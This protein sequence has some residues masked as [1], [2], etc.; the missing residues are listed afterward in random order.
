MLGKI[1]HKLG[2]AG[3]VIAIMALVAALTGVA[4]AAG[5][6][7]K[8][9]EKQVKKIVNKEIQ[10]H[11][12]PQGPKGDPGAPGSQ[13]P[14]GDPGAPG[15]NGQNGISPSGTEFSGEEGACEE[16]GVEIK[17]VNTTLV[18]N[19]KVG[20]T[21]TNLPSEQTLRGLW[22]VELSDMEGFPALITVSFPL[23]VSPAP[24]FKWMGVGAASTAECPGNADEPK[25]A[26]GW[27]C[28]YAGA[29]LNV[30]GPPA[31]VGAPPSIGFR[32]EMFITNEAKDAL[33]YGSWAVTAE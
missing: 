12:G 19:G 8:S 21:E 7:T 15:S 32:G 27:F 16:G 14:K 4:F 29:L 3:L 9:Q 13:G 1:H 23:R 18:C 5:G 31:D 33:A 11:P 10:K 30:T 26:P 22:Q 20:P 6:L 25:A 24:S 2:T 17:G 28:L